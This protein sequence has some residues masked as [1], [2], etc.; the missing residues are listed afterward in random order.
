MPSRTVPKLLSEVTFSIINISE[1]PTKEMERL[2]L[3]SR[4]VAVDE[5]DD[6]AD[7]VAAA[8]EDDEDGGTSIRMLTCDAE[9]TPPAPVVG[10]PELASFDIAE[11]VPGVMEDEDDEDEDDDDEEA[12]VVEV[13]V[14]A[15]V[16]RC[17]YNSGQVRREGGRE[18]GTR[19]E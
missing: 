1:R 2:N 14:A 18:G 10:L 9:P 3:S 11:S 16:A 12:R 7:A 5:E 15:G 8:E 6:E 17:K 4:P 19:V 13:A